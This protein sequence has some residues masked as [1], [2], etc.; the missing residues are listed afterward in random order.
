MKKID[1][2]PEEQN[3]LSQ[4]SVSES[5]WARVARK[6]LIE[7]V[8][9]LMDIRSIDP[10]GNVGL[11]TCANQRAAEIL[12]E[13]FSIIFPSIADEVGPPKGEKISPWR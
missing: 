10:K 4:L 9:E 1:L 6:V 5:A 2:S 13:L 3:A 11:Q 8:N 12:T 7:G